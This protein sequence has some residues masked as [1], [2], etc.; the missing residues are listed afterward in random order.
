MTRLLGVIGDPIAHSLSP[1][2]H[3]SWLRET[4]IDATYEA[5]R[6]FEGDLTHALN[7][8]RDRAAIG[9]NITLPYKQTALSIAQQ[10]SADAAKIGAANT[11]TLL[12]DGIW[13]ADNTDGVGF[14]AALSSAGFGAAK[15][16]R[17]TVLG[18]GGSARAIVHSLRES[19]AD[20]VILNRTIARAEDL[21]LEL[22]GSK[23]VY[24]SIN[25]LAEYAAESALVINTTSFGHSGH[26]FDLETSD[27]QM[28]FDISYGKVAIPQL[29]HA[30][31]QGWQTVDGLSMLV[32][33]A[34]ESFNIWFGERPNVGSALERCRRIVEETT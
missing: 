2:I 19:G 11:L 14:I 16:K 10:A 21:S 34:A 6:V 22:T 33:Q 23:A 29:T 32:A 1:L 3:N 26:Y 8:L 20:I 5:M 15:G 25:Q 18:A 17:I 12:D 13:R 24:G 7:T 27:G 28:F 30:A 4:G 9:V 31:A